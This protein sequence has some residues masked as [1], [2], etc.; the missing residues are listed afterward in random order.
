MKRTQ[1]FER[2]LEEAREDITGVMKTYI[3]EIGV[4]KARRDASRNGFVRIC[5]QQEIDRLT[6]EK[7]AIELEIVG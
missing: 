5:A 7:N 4:Q 2:R 6:A 3:R 1:R